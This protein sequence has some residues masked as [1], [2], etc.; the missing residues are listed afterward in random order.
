MSHDEQDDAESVDE[1][2]IDD[3]DPT[4]EHEDV[5]FPADRPRGLPFADADITDESVADR[6][7]QEDPEVS[8][9]DIDETA[10]DGVKRVDVDDV[11]D[12]SWELDR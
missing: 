11:E 7:E 8:E 2:M 10:S 6:V 4:S 9:R 5:Q 12:P 3:D 1:E